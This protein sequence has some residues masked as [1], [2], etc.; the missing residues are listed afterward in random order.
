MRCGLSRKFSKS[1]KIFVRIVVGHGIDQSLPVSIGQNY[2]KRFDRDLTNVR[3]EDNNV[4]H[5]RG[6]LKYNRVYGWKRLALKVEGKFADEIW[7]GGILKQEK[8]KQ[9]RSKGQTRRKPSNPEE[10]AVSYHGMSR[11]AAEKI[12]TQGLRTDRQKR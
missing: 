3:A 5:K 4:E 2:K 12:V 10:W 11:E 8:R 7:L 9:S 6:N 1:R